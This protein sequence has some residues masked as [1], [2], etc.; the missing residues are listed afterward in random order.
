[1]TSAGSAPESRGISNSSRAWPSAAVSVE[2]SVTSA[3]PSIRA[4][5]SAPATASPFC[6]FRTATC[7]FARFPASQLFALINSSAS[8][9]AG[10]AVRM[11]RGIGIFFAAGL[12]LSRQWRRHK[13][14]CAAANVFGHGAMLVVDPLSERHPRVPDQAATNRCNYLC[15]DA[16]RGRDNK[17][18]CRSRHSRC[19]D[20]RSG[21]GRPTLPLSHPCY[22]QRALIS[23]ASSLAA[24]R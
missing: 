3:A 6:F 5:T 4:V 9:G 11:R 20:L 19:R 8:G 7:K 12:S 10:D 17:Q 15:G 18:S 14:Q 24:R 2:N 23:S 1:M 22:A 16:E 13:L 21:R